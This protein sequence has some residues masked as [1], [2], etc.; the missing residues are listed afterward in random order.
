MNRHFTILV[1]MS[2]LLSGI[3]VQAQ[4]LVTNPG[5][6]LKNHCPSD[7]SEID[8][9]E[10]NFFPTV[11]DWACPVNTTPDY[12]NRCG[13]DSTIKVP[14]LAYDGF[15]E[16]HSGD[17]ILSVSLCFPVIFMHR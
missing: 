4:N 7:R 16:P 8:G 10:T 11:L 15:H 3:S 12:F 14:N 2:A 6:E 9:I 17:A 5:F 13:T 1:L